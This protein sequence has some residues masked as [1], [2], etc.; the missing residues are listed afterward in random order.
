MT[1]AYIALKDHPHLNALQGHQI[2]MTSKDA[3]ELKMNDLVELGVFKEISDEEAL[4]MYKKMR[5][6]HGDKL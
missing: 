3:E 1:K 6:E 5:E 2:I 4:T